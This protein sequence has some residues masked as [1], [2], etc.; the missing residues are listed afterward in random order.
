MKSTINPTALLKELKKMSQIVKKNHIIP[1]T[2][3]VLLSFEKD[4]LTITATDLETTYISIIDCT[5]K[6]SFSFPIDYFDIVEICSSVFTPITIELKGTG[7]SITS[8]KSKFKLSV[9]GQTIDF[10]KVPNDEYYHEM[11]VDGEFFF[12]LGY[13]NSCRWKVNALNPS[14]D[15]AAVL[16]GK[17]EMDIIGCDGFIMYKKTIKAKSEKELSIMI[18]ERFI[19]L[20]KSFQE[21]KISVGER[22][23]KAEYNNEIIISR[24][25]E[26]K[27]PNIKA[28]LPN[29]I[30]YN[31]TLSKDELK[32]SLSAISVASNITSKQFVINFDKDKI[33]LKSQNIDFE[34][35]AETTIETDHKVPFESICLNSSQLLHLSTIIETDDINFQFKDPTGNV[36][37]QPNGDDSILM[38]IRPLAI[39]N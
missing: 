5:S 19:M 32:L 35:E 22:F 8:D 24:L 3:S 14:L 9:S 26:A 1:I 21:T 4:K 37:L 29:E 36:F 15:M 16:V 17:K 18:C 11:N 7:V 30:E 28:L 12:H 6:E 13:A 2:S 31:M 38:L 23:I 34:K 27:Y 20:C 33:V 10:P 25:S 39:N